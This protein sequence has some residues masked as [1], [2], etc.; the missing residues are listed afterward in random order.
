MSQNTCFEL[1]LRDFELNFTKLLFCCLCKFWLFQ[2]ITFQNYLF[3]SE[4]WSKI[5]FQ[6][7][8]DICS[9]KYKR[10][11]WW[12]FSN[13]SVPTIFSIRSKKCYRNNYTMSHLIGCKK[14]KK[15]LQRIHLS[16][17][18]WKTTST[19]T[20]RASVT[21]TFPSFQ[22]RKRSYEDE[23]LSKTVSASIWI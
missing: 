2:V 22:M 9:K 5:L 19:L 3:P 7:S 23:S 13:Y 1:R 8:S 10:R 11:N 18:K 17:Y 6:V 14:L 16:G 21:L 15:N 12:S 4:K 20:K